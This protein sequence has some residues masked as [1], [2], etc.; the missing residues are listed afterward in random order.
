LCR[1]NIP[2]GDNGNPPREIS[3]TYSLRSLFF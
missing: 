3:K 1:F 2:E